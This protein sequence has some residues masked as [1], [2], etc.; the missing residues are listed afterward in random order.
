MQLAILKLWSGFF[1]K[2]IFTRSSK[3]LFIDFW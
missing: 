2:K 3:T 1:L